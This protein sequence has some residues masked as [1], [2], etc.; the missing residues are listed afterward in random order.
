MA[1]IQP[2]PTSLDPSSEAAALAGPLGALAPKA[3]ARW[4][5][6][7]KS[8]VAD[9]E[10]QLDPTA[11]HLV[12][13]G[14]VGIYGSL[15]MPRRALDQRGPGALLGALAG[16]ADT[17]LVCESS[18]QLLRWEGPAAR[19]LATGDQ[20]L[21]RA[22]ESSRAERRTVRDLA[23][24]PL[25]AGLPPPARRMLLRFLRIGHS[26]PNTAFIRQGE[27]TGEFY[28]V[29]S[30]IVTAYRVDADGQR[31][32]LVQL[33]PG[34]WFG[35]TSALSQQPSPAKLQ[36]DTA[37][38]YGVLEP[39]LFKELYA[40][41]SSFRTSIDEVYRRR[42]LAIHLAIVPALR[43]LPREA[44][45]ALQRV[46]R[47]ETFKKDQVAARQ[48]ETPTAVHLVRS[49]AFTTH[50]DRGDG[51]KL[52][53]YLMSNSSF[54]ESALFPEPTPWPHTLVAMMDSDVLVLPAEEVRRELAGIPGA[55]ALL[56][57]GLADLAAEEHEAD[58]EELGSMVQGQSAKGGE[59]LV[60]DLEKCVRCNAC[61]ESCVAVHADRVP[62]LSKRG[63]RVSA[64]ANTMHKEI[65]LVTS[66]YSCGT[67]GCML[68]CNY[69]AIRRN[70]RGLVR[71]LWDNCV[72]CASCV[73]GC[74]YDVIRLTPPPDQMPPPGPTWMAELPVV[75]GW[76][77]GLFGP[78]PSASKTTERGF[79]KDV[80]V[81]GKAVKCDRC[82]G[83]P[84]EACVYN[85][86]T[87]A[88]ERRSPAE[89]FGRTTG[90]EGGR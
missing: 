35:E 82:E 71:F 59:A 20:A 72:G 49:G 65:S 39:G 8:V 17:H 11:V 68:A 46:A 3:R 80:E 40:A 36:A 41:R 45:A 90:P 25:F 7:A 32:Q 81:M 58:Q 62:R 76:L 89:I 48:G 86:P 54:G 56:E 4:L 53:G 28:V 21:E 23:E 6:A 78:K 87:G 63:R 84:F 70:S 55:L 34:E 61:V 29:L 73:Q 1:Q 9:K 44:R 2:P 64:A 77:A 30:G 60:I 12:V 57:Q 51:P 14:T 74:P 5:A 79:H 22:L 24:L 52:T 31:G 85:C 13:Q 18:C 16:D 15:E 50:A 38:V 19:D 69:G 42:S 47:F 26:S 83:L 27:Y 66:C 67:P 37:C 75:G 33:G 43:G 10:T 88:I